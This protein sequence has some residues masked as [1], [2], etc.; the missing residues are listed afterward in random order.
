M[1]YN[2]LFCVPVVF[3]LFIS[4]C[5]YRNH[6]VSSCSEDSRSHRSKVSLLYFDNLDWLCAAE[7]LI[8]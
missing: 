8:C 1:I 4:S 6:M 5:R 2:F 7:A 3:L